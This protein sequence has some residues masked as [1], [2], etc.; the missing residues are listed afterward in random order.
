[1]PYLAPTP[2]RGKRNESLYLLK[3]V[4]KLAAIYNCTAADIAKATTQN[5]RDVFGI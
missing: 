3:V 1:A 5:A 4:D 2:H